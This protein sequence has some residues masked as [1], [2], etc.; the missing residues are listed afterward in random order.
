MALDRKI[1]RFARQALRRSP[2]RRHAFAL[3]ASSPCRLRLF[4]ASRQTRPRMRRSPRSTPPRNGQRSTR[5]SPMSWTS[6]RRASMR[7]LARRPKCWPARSGPGPS[8]W[9]CPWLRLAGSASWRAPAL[10]LSEFARRRTKRLVRSSPLLGSPLAA[11]SANRS[12]AVSPTT[13]AHVVADL[14]GRV[15][16][17]LDGGP[18]R[19]GLEFDDRRLS[20]AVGPNC[21]VRER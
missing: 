4:T 20:W 19:Y 18:C 21:C 3:E 2:T 10:T 9:S 1:T 11:P 5:S 14:D 8:R 7:S 6:R 12:G 17:I 13:A 16:W 15:D